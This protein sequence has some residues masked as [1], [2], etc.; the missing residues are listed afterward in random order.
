MELEG[1]GVRAS[2]VHPG[3]TSTH[4]GHQLT[5]EQLE[6]MLLDWATW[7]HTRHGGFLQAPDI[8]QAVAFVA[9]ARP[10]SSVVA[11]EMQPEAPLAAAAVS[12]GG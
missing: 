6:P 4:M 2:I 3:Q 8:A 7:G 10:G 1:T 12:A 9:R 11:V 5:P